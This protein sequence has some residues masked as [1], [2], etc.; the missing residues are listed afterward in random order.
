MR[1]KILAAGFL[2]LHVTLLTKAQV[3]PKI[4]QEGLRLY[5]KGKYAEALVY[6]QQY[7]Q[8]K[9]DDPEVLKPMA[10]AAFETNKLSVAKQN[11]AKL[12]DL[13]KSL[14][15]NSTLHLAYI[16]HAELN[17]KEAIKYYKNYL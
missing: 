14:D 7:T 4:K 1:F 13:Q 2:L 15:A 9:S 11:F 16:A 5:D 6:L 12:W 8:K 17:F 10:L 3:L